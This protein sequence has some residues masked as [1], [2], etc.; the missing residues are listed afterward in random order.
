MTSLGVTTLN[1]ND[2]ILINAQS[3]D[4][5]NALYEITDASDSSNGNYTISLVANTNTD[6]A[7]LSN[8]SDNFIRCGNSF[9]NIGTNSRSLYKRSS[10]SSSIT[11]AQLNCNANTFSTIANMTHLTEDYDDNSKLYFYTTHGTAG[12]YSYDT[13]TGDILRKLNFA[14]QPLQLLIRPY[15]P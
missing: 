4:A 13:S 5:E 6:G 1:V 7:L 9:I 8:G 12:I 11:Q 15:S 3:N 14:T 2:K 10:G